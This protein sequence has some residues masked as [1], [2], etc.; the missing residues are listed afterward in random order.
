MEA[1]SR[2][3]TE[4]IRESRERRSARPTVSQR[5]T[6]ATPDGDWRTLREVADRTGIPIGTLRKWCRRE[7]VDSYLESDGEQALRMLEMGSVEEHAKA[8]G[9]DLGERPQSPVPGPQQEESYQLPATSH[10]PEPVLGT[11]Y[12]VPSTA[13]E[14]GSTMIVPVDAWNKM[15]TQLGNLHEAGQQLAE[16]RERAGKAETEARFLRERLAE[17]RENQEPRA[18]SQ[19]TPAPSTD[20]ASPSPDSSSSPSGGGVAEG[21]RGGQ[22]ETADD[23]PQPGAPSEDMSTTSNEIETTS[24]FRYVVRG[25]RGRKR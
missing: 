7:S 8:M 11:Q 13:D 6:T 19:A 22:I 25:W 2:W 9:R 15:L 21:G 10:Q 17:L 14:V 5:R 4:A 16:A 20:D 12:S 23:R 24:F 3:E 1:A 18:K